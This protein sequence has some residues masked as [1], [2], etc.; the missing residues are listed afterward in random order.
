MTDDPRWC[1][2]GTRII[3]A[4][5]DAEPHPDVKAMR[6]SPLAFA[7]PAGVAMAAWLSPPWAWLSVA[8][9]LL[10]VL[11]LPRSAAAQT[12]AE[13]D[14][15]AVRSV[16]E[17]QLAALA[18]DDA[19]KAF[20]YASAS[21]RERFGDAATFMAMVQT[22][23]PMIVRPASVAFFVPTINAG[24][25][26]QRVQMRDRNGALWLASYELQKQADASWRINGCSVTAD[27]G[28][29]ST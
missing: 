1:D 13:H 8:L 6:R 25:V 19:E 11:G 3:D 2:C 10:A 26:L 12:L 9:M 5:W 17:A 7:R 20:S 16:V 29:S 4:R 21:I 14:A 27:S 18:A 23:Y 28:K 15:R 22:G 24:A